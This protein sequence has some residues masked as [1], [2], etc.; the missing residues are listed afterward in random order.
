MNLVVREP[1]ESIGRSRE[2]DLNVGHS[3]PA[4]RL[5]HGEKQ[6]LAFLSGQQF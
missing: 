1:R 3:G 4:S 5:F 6:L 2:T